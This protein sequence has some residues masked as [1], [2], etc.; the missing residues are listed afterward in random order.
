[1]TRHGFRPAAGTPCR[2][3]LSVN[4]FECYICVHIPVP[5][6]LQIML[7]QAWQSQQGSGSTSSGPSTAQQ[8]TFT[9]ALHSRGRLGEQHAPSEPA[10]SR[11]PPAGSQLMAEGPAPVQC[12]PTATPV[13][14]VLDHAACTSISMLPASN[15]AADT[16]AQAAE[17]RMPAQ[18]SLPSEEVLNSEGLTSASLDEA[19]SAA[20]LPARAASFRKLP[21][22]ALPDRG[23]SAQHS[24]K[25]ALADNLDPQPRHDVSHSAGG[26]PLGVLAAADRLGEGRSAEQVATSVPS[27]TPSKSSA[28][29]SPAYQQPPLDQQPAAASQLD[30]VF[31][32]SAAQPAQASS[33]RESEVAAPPDD[34]AQ[35][36]RGSS[37]AALNTVATG[38]SASADIRQLT[39]EISE[40][41][42]MDRDPI[43]GSPVRRYR[44]TDDAE[45]HFASVGA[46]DQTQPA[47]A[48]ALQEGGDALHAA[49]QQGQQERQL[50]DFLAALEQN[51]EQAAAVQQTK[52][53]TGDLLG[54]E[55]VE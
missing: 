40:L 25:A 15:G 29:S 52:H 46:Q 5:D 48:E 28:G 12:L 35:H 17:A 2:C 10:A 38:S 26:D 42:Y 55:S 44:G 51:A 33:T 13:D 24:L 32:M 7:L 20:E 54:Q 45:E 43:H 36:E 9:Q 21:S 4:A 11:Q 6:L 27:Y 1:M 31:S 50:S 14:S 34:L 49:E 3:W 53:G 30:T 18:L 22:F 41:A 37:Q 23:P 39:R 16:E 19:G 47:A 8:Q